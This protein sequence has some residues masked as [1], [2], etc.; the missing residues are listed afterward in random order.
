VKMTLLGAVP[1]GPYGVLSEL[2]DKDMPAKAAAVNSCQQSLSLLID[3]TTQAMARV[4]AHADGAHACC[5]L[6]QAPLLQ[7][8]QD[9][10]S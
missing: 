4:L 7:P 1:G 10:R 6:S 5:G 3:K 9:A 8:F 2:S